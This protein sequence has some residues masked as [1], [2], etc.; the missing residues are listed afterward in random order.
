MDVSSITPSRRT[1]YIPPQA[2]AAAKM[3][4]VAG[5]QDVMEISPEARAALAKQSGAAEGVGD[6]SGSGGTAAAFPSFS[7]EFN[8][9]TQGYSD[10]VREHYAQEHAGN[11][12]FDNP[13]AHVWD[14]Y[15][16]A[17]SP[18]FRAGLSE[19]ERAWAYDHELDLLNS[20]GKHMQL[21]NPY[22]FPGGAP[23]LESA[24]MQEVQAC[25]EQVGQ[26]VQDL[27]AQNDI[28]LPAD[29]FF[30]LT[31]DSKHTIRVSGLDEKLTASVEEAL[32]IGDN[33][34]IF[35]IF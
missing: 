4:S 24:A 3:P 8:K 18:Y 12:A 17:E 28:E 35:I 31:V 1:A 23:T 30:R 13:K 20:G 32:N 25:R 2:S 19:D 5:A 29:A 14:K 15:K 22:A 34:K 21:T 9:I 11:L 33:G 27:L 6:A 16:N 26:S 7:D 10:A